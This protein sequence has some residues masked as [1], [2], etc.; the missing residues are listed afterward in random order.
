MEASINSIVELRKTNESTRMFG[1]YEQNQ[2]SSS[3]FEVIFQEERVHTLN[4]E[5]R[6]IRRKSKSA[7]RS[8]REFGSSIGRMI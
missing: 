2:Q 1:H 3:V 6:N 4:T 7:L 8:A 5:M